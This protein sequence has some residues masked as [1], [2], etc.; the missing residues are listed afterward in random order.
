MVA[1]VIIQSGFSAEVELE[2]YIIVDEQLNRE[3]PLI[4]VAFALYRVVGNWFIYGG[5][6]VELEKHKK[7][8]FRIINS[9]YFTFCFIRIF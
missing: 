4:L 7:E 5:V 8:L 6:G 3:N 9:R 1:A 2:S